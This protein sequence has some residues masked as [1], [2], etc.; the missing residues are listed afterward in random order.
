MANVLLDGSAETLDSPSA[1]M[2]SN[3]GC[4]SGKMAERPVKIEVCEERDSEAHKDVNK[5]ERVQAQVN[6]IDMGDMLDDASHDPRRD[7]GALNPDALSA[8]SRMSRQHRPF[9]RPQDTLQALSPSRLCAPS[10][11]RVLSSNGD[12]KETREPDLWVEV[13]PPPFTLD[14][15]LPSMRDDR[16]SVTPPPKPTPVSSRRRK[17]ISVSSA[18]QAPKALSAH[19]T[20]LAHSGARAGSSTFAADPSTT[21]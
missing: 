8:H 1:E 11:H 19:R 17:P 14:Q 10:A 4:M 21:I 12:S 15:Y 5:E 16:I 3:S 9:K 13:P 2:P 7:D 6:V 20:S 18:K